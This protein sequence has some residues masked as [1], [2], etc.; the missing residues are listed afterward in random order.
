ML[1]KLRQ[2]TELWRTQETKRNYLEP[3]EGAEQG[4]RAE[5]CACGQFLAAGQAELG[6]AVEGADRR[7]GLQGRGCGAHRH[8]A[9]L[10]A[11]GRSS[12]MRA[13]GAAGQGQAELGGLGR[14]GQ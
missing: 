3:V 7:A 6:G 9:E 8:R 4:C 13:A 11:C 12:W 2:V 1:T 10:C 5:L 14:R